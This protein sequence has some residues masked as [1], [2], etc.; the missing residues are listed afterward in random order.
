M[1]KHHSKW[2]NSKDTKEF[3]DS[4]SNIKSS[5]LSISSKTIINCIKTNYKEKYT[6]VNTLKKSFYSRID[7]VKNNDTGEK[8][9]MKSVKSDKNMP[10]ELE[11]EIINEIF[12][13]K[14]L[15][16]PQIIKIFEFYKTTEEYN[17][18]T[19][20]CENGDLYNELINEA[21]FSEDYAA[22]ILYQLLIALNCC[23]KL[24]ILY[25]G[26]DPENILIAE[27]NDKKYPQIKMT[28]F[29]SSKIFHKDIF[30]EKMIGSPYYIAPEAIY[31]KKYNEKCDL[32]SCGVILYMMLSGKVPFGG[33][34]EEEILKMVEKGSFNLSR[35]EFKKVS[36]SAIDLIKALLTVSPEK[37]LSAEEALNHIWFK[38]L[39][40]KE[41]YNQIKDE[42][43]INKLI[44]NIENYKRTSALQETALA[45]L[46]HNF[47]Q[48][49]DVVNACKLFSQIDIDDD[50]KINEDELFKGLKVKLRGKISKKEVE[51][52]FKK[53]D[54]DGNGF[55]EYEEFVRAAVDK[56]F[57]VSD[58]IIQYAF[59]FFDKD[60]SGIITFDEIREVFESS[61]VQKANEETT[62]KKI[63][64]EV[65][66]KKD[67]TISYKEFEMAMKKLIIAKN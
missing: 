20:Y 43:T 1:G 67:G 55:I 4:N 31:N 66:E 61:L 21:P 9:V 57:F 26:L 5:T 45:Y 15:D 65:D 51:N 32:W 47:P 59:K 2:V 19:E 60:N 6:Y 18:I 33:H 50:G 25:R 39:K 22:Y 10:K 44:K 23:H 13:L 35:K 24:H 56:E 46:V 17:I 49:P 11:E 53:L 38:E 37:R 40:I 62:L 12:I 14:K 8:R 48:M 29:G 64:D 3:T 54:M 58:E 7:L 42:N 27:R 63:I 16:H 28:N 34:N 36:K 41:I 52:I 30:N